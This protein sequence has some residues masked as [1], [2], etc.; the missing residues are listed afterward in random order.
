MTGKIKS[1]LALLILDGWGWREQAEG[2][3]IRLAQTP[4]YDEILAKYPMTLLEASGAR[5]GL[6][7]GVMGNS[8]VGHLNIGSGRV[9]RTDI[10]RID[11]AIESG[12]LFTN[13][14]LV[15]TMQ[16]AARDGKQLHF[17]G[18]VSDGMVHSSNQH[19]YALLE[20][21]K[22]QQVE[23]VFIHAFLDGRDTPPM[24]AEGF[25]RDLQ[26]KINDIGTGKI[27]TLIGR[28]YAMDRDQRWERTKLAYDLLIEGTGQHIVDAASGVHNMYE[29]G[30]TDEF[31]TPL[32]VTDETNQPVSVMRE[33]DAVIFFNYRAD[34]ARQTTRALTD[35]NFA[36]FSN[37]NR[38]RLN[39]VCMTQYDKTFG[40][41]FVFAP[42][43][44]P[45]IL[46]E[47]LARESLNNYRLAETEKYA[48]VTYFFN[49]GTEK[50]FACESRL[51]VPSQKV[52][53]YDL[54]PEMSVF[55]ITDKALRLMDEGDTDIYIINFANADMVGHSGRLDKTIEAVQYVDTCLGWIMKA[56][57]AR[58]GQLLV[59]A[60]H[61]NAEMM[62]DPETG[63]AHTAHT[64]NLV[65]FH[66]ISDNA[67]SVKFRTGGALE[68]ISPTILGLLDVEQPIEMT[69]RDLREN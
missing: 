12:E 58:G 43:T 11:Y 45:N 3:A 9:I 22:Q 25:I 69:G 8:E 20:M 23:K 57:N 65:P 5:V 17:I 24:S 14:L 63:G 54:A 37:A 27:A 26:T 62:I 4:Y 34:R 19:L 6:P 2:N 60:D 35:S 1:P 50:E 40:L 13:E 18:L 33:D 49:G 59:T 7:K 29:Q 28:F 66:L 56:I 31:I 10:G 46:G 39:F 15:E 36:G 44:R 55:K 67:Q 64:T 32:V 16:R 68:D 30:V 48:H 41:P 21:A 47:I 38:P 53:T 42:E 52:T 51:L 61:G